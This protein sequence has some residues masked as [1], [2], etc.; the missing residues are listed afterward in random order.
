MPHSRRGVASAALVS[1][2]MM[3]APVAFAGGTTPLSV[4]ACRLFSNLHD[5]A[6][7][8]IRTRLMTPVQMLEPPSFFGERSCSKQRPIFLGSPLPGADL[9]TL[10]ALQETIER[11]ERE[12]KKHHGHAWYTVTTT[13]VG[14]IEDGAKSGRPLYLVLRPMSAT[15]IVLKGG[16]FPQLE[17]ANPQDAAPTPKP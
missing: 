5:F 11:G 15:D 6:S 14:T 17:E 16:T 10:R 1:V 13:L 12:R 4:S 3:C 2:A 7:V 9:A 8:L